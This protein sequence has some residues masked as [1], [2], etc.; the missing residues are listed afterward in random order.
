MEERYVNIKN[1]LDEIKAGN[2]EPVDIGDWK[3]NNKRFRLFMLS[4]ERRGFGWGITSGSNEEI[5]RSSMEI[6]LE[7]EPDAAFVIEK[8][9]A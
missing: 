9:E 3:R 5:L 1:I 6:A 7:I 4:K 2:N 8:G